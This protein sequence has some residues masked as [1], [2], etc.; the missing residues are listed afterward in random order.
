[1]TIQETQLWWSPT[2]GFSAD[3]N[4]QSSPGSAWE[5]VDGRSTILTMTAEQAVRWKLASGRASTM[6][7]VLRHLGL[8]DQAQVVRM[9][10]A[11]A[12]YNKNLDRKFADLVKQV[13]NYFSAIGGL[14]KSLNELADAYGKKDR[15]AANL[16][17]SDIGRQVAK[18]SNAGRAIQKIDKS[19]LARRMEVPDEAIAQI[20]ADAQLLSKLN[21]L[22][23][24]DTVEGFNESAQRMNAVLESWRK[25]LRLSS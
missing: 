10:D 19:L 13:N 3:K 6:D 5:E 15:E 2:A 9:D 1:M 23:R 17:K 4:P 7:G 21:R 8:A 25:L 18:L 20:E 11:I 16:L 12:Q 14:V 24:T 22:L